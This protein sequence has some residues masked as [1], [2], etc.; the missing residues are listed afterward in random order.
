MQYKEYGSGNSDVILLLHGGG[1][2]WWNYRE[3]AEQLQKDYH[4]I[5]P[6]LDGHGGSDRPFSG[7]EENAQ[8]IIDFIDRELGGSVLLMGGIS[9]GAQILLEILSRRSHICRYAVVESALVLPSKLT[10]A[11]IRPVFSGCYGL[12]RQQWFAKVQAA[13]LK[14]PKPLFEDYFRDTCRISRE[15]MIAFLEANAMYS[16]NASIRGCTAQVSVL[17]GK[18][19]PGSMK[20]SAKQI[21]EAIPGSSLHILPG[22]QHGEFSLCRGSDNV[23]FLRN[24]MTP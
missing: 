2:S 19:E 1:L 10:H 17:V 21:H 22:L 12:I 23:G 20:H 14:I 11:L 9:L 4:V 24:A 15:S 3:A 5:L 13:Y 6:I 18:K 16:L 8:E 7:I